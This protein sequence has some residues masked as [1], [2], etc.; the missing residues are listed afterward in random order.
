VRLVA[1]GRQCGSTTARLGLTFDKLSERLPR[2]LGRLMVLKQAR[3]IV[4]RWRGA[5]LAVGATTGQKITGAIAW[6]ASAGLCSVDR[7]AV[8]T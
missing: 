6:R 1:P 7:F 5:A 3:E 4:A 8:R 2:R